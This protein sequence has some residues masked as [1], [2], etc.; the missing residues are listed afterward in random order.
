MVMYNLPSYSNMYLYVFTF[1]FPKY[2]QIC[3]VTKEFN[4]ATCH[5]LEPSLI[6]IVNNGDQY[7]ENKIICPKNF[8][9]PHGSKLFKVYQNLVTTSP[10]SVFF[11]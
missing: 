9:V 1:I 3:H 6:I 10:C 5:N 7:F 2:I 4:Y 8:I 11:T